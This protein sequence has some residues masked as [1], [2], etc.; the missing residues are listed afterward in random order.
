M[1]YQLVPPRLPQQN[2]TAVERVLTNRGIAL[3]DIPHYLSTTDDDILDPKLIAYI[4]DGARMLVKHIYSNDK[5]LIQVDSDCDGMTSAA[6]L[7]N[8]LNC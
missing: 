1:S 4:N 7:I 2:L 8:Y 3:E 5:V 6:L